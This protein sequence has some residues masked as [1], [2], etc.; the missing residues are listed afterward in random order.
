MMANRVTGRKKAVLS[1][2]LH[3]H[4]R[5]VCATYARFAGFEVAAHG[6]G[7]GRRRGP[8]AARRRR[9]RVRRRAEPRFLGRAARLVGDLAAGLPRQGRAAGRRGDRDAVA[10]RGQAARRDGRRHRRRRRAVARQRAQF[11]RASSR[12]LRDPRQIRA[13]DAG[14]ARRPD[15]RRRR[16]ARLGVDAVDPRAAHPARE[17]D[18]QYLHQ[19]GAVRARLY[20]PSGIARRD[21][22]WRGWRGS[23]MPPRC[24]SPSGSSSAGR[25][26]RQPRVLQRV[27]P[28]PA[29]PGGAGGRGARRRRRSRRHAG[30]PT[31]S[32]ARR[33]WPICCWSRRPRRRPKAT[34]IG[35]QWAWRRLLR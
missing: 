19:F 30:E 7:T 20:D 11:R 5:E 14:P 25:A 16:P 32:G 3:P 31:L 2:G 21:R 1:G 17:G 26:A 35:W 10:G 34:W 9:N 4:Y 18:E 29:V 28:A 15:R 8:G 24:G 13:A 33:T 27:H 23:T 6:P 12:P 22:G